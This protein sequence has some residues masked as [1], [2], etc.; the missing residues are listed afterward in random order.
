[1]LLS[2][3]I[4]VI[5]PIFL[6]IGLGAI[7]D[8]AL[9]LDLATLSRI[10]F[11]ALIPALLFIKIFDANLSPNQ[12]FRIGF[13]ALVHMALLYGI[14]WPLFRLPAWRSRQT[15]LSLATIFSNV[16]NYGIPLVALAYGAEYIGT[17]AIIILVQNMLNFSFGIYLLE[18][19]DR[20]LRQVILGLARIPS[21]HAIWIAL[22][23]RFFHL[24]LP[25]PLRVPVNYL[26][27]GIIP[28]ALL[29][30]GAQIARSSMGDGL[31]ALGLIAGFRLLL[32]PLL[33]ALLVIPFGFSGPTASLL[34]VVAGL[35]VAVNVFILAAEYQ[36]D[37]SFASQSVFWTTLLSALTITMLLAITR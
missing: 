11:N 27:D 25:D 16:G 22:A 24:G 21:L 9:R 28:I 29:S 8:K 20:S 12:M 15:V 30:L 7:L 5:L 4:S 3:I 2:I 31:G 37:E 26:A 17:L 36:R 6:L 23:M 1:M 14:T 10:S 33:A 32:S 19:G 13:F 35:P 18:R 34:I